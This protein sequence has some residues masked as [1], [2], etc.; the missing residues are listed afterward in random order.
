VV[1]V[2]YRYTGRV[3]ILEGVDFNAT[4]KLYLGFEFALGVE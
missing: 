2:M 1:Q 3:M 4:C